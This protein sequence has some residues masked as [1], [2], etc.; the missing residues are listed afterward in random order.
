MFDHHDNLS[1]HVNSY[2]EQ[3]KILCQ[4]CGKEFSRFDSLKHHVAIKMSMS[5]SMCCKATAGKIKIYSTLYSFLTYILLIQ[6][7][8]NSLL[9]T[10][11]SFK[12]NIN[13]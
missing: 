9:K 4:Q 7:T 5:M 6:K 2:H 8:D 1:R 10:N 11:N 3:N 12:T 13:K